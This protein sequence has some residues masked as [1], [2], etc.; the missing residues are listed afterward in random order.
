MNTRITFGVPKINF[1]L[2]GVRM[3]P[4]NTMKYDIYTEWF[5]LMHSKSEKISGVILFYMVLTLHPQ[6]VNTLNSIKL[7]P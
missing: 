1:T 5:G 6:N 7:I 4:Y 2:C 3:E